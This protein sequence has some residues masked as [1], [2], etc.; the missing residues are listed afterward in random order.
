MGVLRRIVVHEQAVVWVG[1]DASQPPILHLRSR[2]G[3]PATSDGFHVARTSWS[4]L[5]VLG[6]EEGRW[7]VGGLP[8]DTLGH[9]IITKS[10]KLTRLMLR[11]MRPTG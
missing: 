9:V 1:I 8:S 6:K 5:A 2:F 7:L 3:Q 10:R 4:N 11:V